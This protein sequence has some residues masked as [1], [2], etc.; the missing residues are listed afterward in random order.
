MN[1][2]AEPCG[3]GH[4]GRWRENAYGYWRCGAPE[5]GEPGGY[6]RW[7]VDKR[8]RMRRQAPRDAEGWGR[9]GIADPNDRQKRDRLA[10]IPPGMT[11]AE[12]CA[13]AEAQARAQ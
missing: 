1:A 4:T 8:G 7:I 5:A 13:R 3:M 11:I 6:C 9:G 2:P 10:A 12:Y